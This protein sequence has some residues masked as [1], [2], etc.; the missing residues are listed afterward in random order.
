[1]LKMYYNTDRSPQR[2]DVYG[3][4]A[5]NAATAGFSRGQCMKLNINSMFANATLEVL[6]NLIDK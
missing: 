2:R 1:M 4:S 3:G 6:E 5:A